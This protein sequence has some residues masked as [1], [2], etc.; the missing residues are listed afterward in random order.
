MDERV[1]RQRMTTAALGLALALLALFGAFLGDGWD[2]YSVG[3]VVV[4][5]V[6]VA[7]SAAAL[8]ALRKR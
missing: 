1:A 7:L 2:G 5:A 4:A 3:L 8:L 6:L